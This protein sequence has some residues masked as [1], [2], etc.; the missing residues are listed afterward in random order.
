[1]NFKNGYLGTFLVVIAIVMTISGS[2]I[3]SFD[4]A[5]STVTKYR[6]SADLTGLFDAEEAPS[7][8]PFNPSANQTG[9]YTDRTTHYFDGVNVTTTLQPNKYRLNLAPIA[10]SSQNDYD[11]D[12]ITSE[13][14][15]QFHVYYWTTNDDRNNLN[16][17]SYTTLPLLITALGLDSQSKV[18]IYSTASPAYTESDNFIT[19][20]T[21]DKLSGGNILAPKAVYF[22][23]P[24]LTGDLEVS[25]GATR[26]AAETDDPILAVSYDK[27]NTYA[28]LWY[29]LD[30]KRPAGVA[31]LSEICIL[32]GGSPGIVGDWIFGDEIDY[33]AELFP[34]NQY[35]VIA[36]G[37]TLEDIA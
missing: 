35:M 4:M 9:Y 31:T 16:Q 1:M 6:S 28:S 27:N 11:L 18:N 14:D 7:F 23:N 3:M 20:T 26:P 33:T 37:V 19:F 25:L 22:K 12:N 34:D 13:S 24:N 21:I 36:D 17:T 29:D 10:T 15:L 2:Y 32:W 30:M 5:E 8:M